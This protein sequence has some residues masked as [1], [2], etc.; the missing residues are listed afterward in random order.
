[1]SA[2]APQ[3]AGG[4]GEGGHGAAREEGDGG[5]RA[6]PGALLTNPPSVLSF[7]CAPRCAAPRDCAGIVDVDSCNAAG[8]DA[9]LIK[10]LGVSDPLT[11]Q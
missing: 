6:T 9:V 8:G 7:L 11:I 2:G 3:H 1:M 5:K 10:I 4:G